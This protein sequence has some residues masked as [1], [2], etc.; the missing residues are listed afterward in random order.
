M[1]TAMA[2]VPAASLL[3]GLAVGGLLLAGSRR[4]ELAGLGAFAFLAAA[5]PLELGPGPAGWLAGGAALAAAGVS[6]WLCLRGGVFRF[7]SGRELKWWRILARPFALLFVPID[8]LFGRTPLLFLLGVLALAFSAL[9]L[10]RLFSRLQLDQLFKPS[11]RKRFSS[12]TSFLVAIFLIFL[13]FPDHLP[14]LGLGFI[15]VGDLFGKIVGLRFGRVPLLRGRTLEGSLAFTSGGLAAAWLLRLALRGQTPPVPLYGVLAGPVV[16][17]LVE[18][19]SG[20]L[21]D[22]FTVGIVSCGFLYSLRY[23]LRA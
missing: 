6:L 15:T 2:G 7:P 11:E 16:A 20:V 14:Y 19:F 5:L 3:A 1:G 4:A 8:R 12:M 9:D 21:D 18:L 10:V 17:A 23:F 13:V 22:N